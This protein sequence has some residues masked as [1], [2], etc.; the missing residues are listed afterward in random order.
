MH[1]HWRIVSA[2]ICN[3]NTFPYYKHKKLN[4]HFR[5]KKTIM[6]KLYVLSLAAAMATATFAQRSWNTTQAETS[7]K[8]GFSFRAKGSKALQFEPTGSNSQKAKATKEETVYDI[9]GCKEGAVGGNELTENTGWNGEYNADAGRTELPVKWFQHFDDV[10]YTF[11]KVRFLGVF[12]HWDGSDW[13]YCH[14]RGNQDADFNMTEPIVIEVGIYEENENGEPGKCIF[15][16]DMPIIGTK[17]R[18]QTG[19]EPDV[20]PIYEFVADL[21]QEIDLEHGFVQFNAKDMGD[22]PTCWFALFCAGNDGQSALTFDVVNEEYNEQMPAVFCLYGD[23][24]THNAKKALQLERFMTPNTTANGKYEKVQVELF[25]IGENDIKDARLELYVDDQLVTTENV[26]ATIEAYDIYKYTFEYRV[27]C[28]EPHKITVKNVTPG[29]EKKSYESISMA[30]EPATI[31]EYPKCYAY[32]PGYYNITEVKMGSINN[33][34]EGSDYSDYTDQKTTI[35]M[36]STETLNLTAISMP[37][38]IEPVVGIFIDWNGD[39]KFTYDEYVAFESFDVTGSRAEGYKGVGVAKVSVPGTA[40]AGEHRMRLVATDGDTPNPNDSFFY[41]EVEDY[42]VIVEANPSDPKLALDKNVVDQLLTTST[43]NAEVTL[44]NNGNGNLNANV[45]YS[46]VLPGMPT[47]TKTGNAAP[48]KAF[49]G[50]LKMAR[51]AA[52]KG[53]SPVKDPATQYVLKYDG[54]NRDCIGL[55]NADE[56]IFMSMY[57]GAM[58]SNLNGMKLSS[59]DVFIGDV[60]ASASIVVYGQNK[61]NATGDL[62]VEK[63]FTPT[64]QSWNHITLDAPV[65]IGNTDLWIGVKMTGLTANKYYIGTDNGPA[66]RGFGDLVNIGGDTWWS[67]GD[68][69]MNYNYSIRANISGDR[70]AAI[71]WLSVD[72]ETLN[73]APHTTGKVG[74]N[75]SAQG[76]NKGLYE[77]VIELSCNDPFNSFNKIPVYMVNSSVTGITLDNNG[78]A[79][80]S[81]D[82]TTLNVNTGKAINGIAVYDL[83]GRNMINSN[84]NTG[85]ISLATL[86]KGVYVVK[87]NHT[88]G[89]SVSVKFPVVK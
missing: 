75:F 58:L 33:Q 65:T 46:Y 40:T 83:N 28:T 54:E 66:V 4:E 85:T 36:G 60:P 6:K 8:Y 9:L 11:N 48:G 27:D 61:Q 63:V 39:H 44:T 76:L 13:F 67:M 32:V 50:N 79:G 82:G 71:N 84:G 77:A 89:T 81:L 88:D 74:I 19:Y 25:N 62:I 7:N 51:K 57:P 24:V 15:K 14:E 47:L 17:T 35:T 16:K 5:G 78:K 3:T 72:K 69:G 30:T 12:N 1:R 22:N 53:V 59:I 38:E 70:T 55:G 86:G 37:R 56:A 34:S 18:I 26:N 43:G 73:L 87:V 10:F 64:K 20:T 41:G 80:I 29:D 52:V 23:G 42:T 2:E 49:K 21:G 45:E 68:L 31:G